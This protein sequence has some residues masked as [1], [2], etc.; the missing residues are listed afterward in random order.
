MLMDDTGVPVATVRRALKTLLQ[1]RITEELEPAIM[2]RT[3]AGPKLR[4]NP[5]LHEW[6]YR[7]LKGIN[8][9]PFYSD[10]GDHPKP[11][12]GRS[13]LA[14]DNPDA[15][16]VSENTTLTSGTLKSSSIEK[17]HRTEHTGES[18]NSGDSYL[19]SLLRPLFVRFWRAYPKKKNQ[20]RAAE[21]FVE[22]MFDDDTEDWELLLE[23]MLTAIEKQK[24]SL[25]WQ[26]PD[27]I[28]HPANWLRDR[29]WED[30]D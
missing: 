6:K 5:C 11:G 22:V 26:D 24:R 13:P 9:D 12:L 14:A 20:P 7:P 30:E 29:R 21:E 4:I 27:Y 10:K 18:N 28:P 25:Q 15:V 1:L 23:V 19:S 8:S 3:G 2:G 16:R 17:T